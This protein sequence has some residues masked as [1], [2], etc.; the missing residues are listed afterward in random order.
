M[1]LDLQIL[2]VTEVILDETCKSILISHQILHDNLFPMQH[3]CMRHLFW[4]SMI[5]VHG[6]SLLNFEGVFGENYKAYSILIG[7]FL[8]SLFTKKLQVATKD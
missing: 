1:K 5:S 7:I 4:I 2:K 8:S 3:A 6:G